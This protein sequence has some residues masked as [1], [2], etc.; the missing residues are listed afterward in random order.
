[1]PRWRLTKDH[2]LAPTVEAPKHR[3]KGEIIE[4]DGRRRC[5][6]S[7][8]TMQRAPSLKTRNSNAERKADLLVA[9]SAGPAGALQFREFAFSRNSLV[10]F[11]GALDEYANSRP[12]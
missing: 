2:Y 10:F 5:P 6:W 7:R 8:S 4:F 3:A 11:V 1:M 9:R 12:L